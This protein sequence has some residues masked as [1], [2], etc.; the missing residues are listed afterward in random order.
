MCY[1]EFI[2]FKVS[3]LLGRSYGINVICMHKTGE[4]ESIFDLQSSSNLALSIP[5]VQLMK[6]GQAKA[7]FS[8]TLIDDSR[9]ITVDLKP[10]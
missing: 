7:C 1:Q 8:G 4:R 6:G 2:V 9:R 3:W 10:P 5:T